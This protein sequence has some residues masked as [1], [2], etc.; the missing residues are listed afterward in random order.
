VAENGQI[1]GVV[2][3]VERLGAESYVHFR[4]GGYAMVA[5]VPSDMAI[6]MGETFSVDIEP[7]KIHCFDADGVAL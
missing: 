4:W 6:R 5:Q 1:A 2:E 3:L 7:S